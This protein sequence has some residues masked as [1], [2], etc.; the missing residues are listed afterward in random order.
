MSSPHK[1]V[2]RSP[3]Q[4]TPFTPTILSPRTNLNSL[5]TIRDVDPS[6]AL[7]VYLSPSSLT[8]QTT[9][10]TNNLPAHPAEIPTNPPDLSHHTHEESE[11]ESAHTYA[12]RAFR[13]YRS[14]P[15][16]FK[17]LHI[18]S[19]AQPQFRDI[20]L[21]V[22][23]ESLEK[24]LAP[25]SL[26]TRNLVPDEKSWGLFDRLVESWLGVWGG[27]I[28][29]DDGAYRQEWLVQVEQGGDGGRDGS[30]GGELYWSRAEDRKK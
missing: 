6:G 4:H 18:N 22:K 2:N 16:V 3:A 19:S 9:A 29:S 28:W 27:V 5:N 11:P 14:W 30:V 23:D 10:N 24:K 1:S 21:D 20:V 25:H 8:P 12:V 7:P 13:P 26:Q 17:A 15:R